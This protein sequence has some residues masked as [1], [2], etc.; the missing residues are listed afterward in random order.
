M[1]LTA[2]RVSVGTT[3]TLIVSADADGQHVTVRNSDGVAAVVLG[4]PTVT[5]LNG[6]TLP[7]TASITLELPAGETLYGIVAAGT[8]DVHVL[9]ARST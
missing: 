7:A 5:A 3:P 1:A 9:S 6:Y 8:V 2:A 4:S